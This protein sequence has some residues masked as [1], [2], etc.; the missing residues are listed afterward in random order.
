[1][2]F[3]TSHV[4]SDIFLGVTNGV[5]YGLIALSLVI[6]WR[7]TSILNFAQGAMAMFATTRLRLPPVGDEI[8][9]VMVETVS[10]GDICRV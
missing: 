7:A 3:L 4:M 1:M 5:L 6:V 2:N 9:G 10:P 8:V